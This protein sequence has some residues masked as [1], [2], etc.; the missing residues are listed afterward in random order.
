M[1]YVWSGGNEAYRF[2]KVKNRIL[3]FFFMSKIDMDNFMDFVSK[4]I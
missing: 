1:I 2:S 3:D 4:D